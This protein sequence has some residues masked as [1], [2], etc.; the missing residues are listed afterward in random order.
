MNKLG[1]D[2]E[3]ETYLLKLA[4][5]AERGSGDRFFAKFGEKQ[6]ELMKEA[7]QHYLDGLLEMARGQSEQAESAFL[8]ALELNPSHSWARAHLGEL[9]R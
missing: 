9:K 8:K 3:A 5:F 1:E 2:E 7:E 6:S 4:D